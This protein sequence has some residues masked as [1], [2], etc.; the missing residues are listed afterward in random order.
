MCDKNSKIRV[1]KES[2]HILNDEKIRKASAIMCKLLAIL[3]IILNRCK[4]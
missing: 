2:Q 4:E 3:H 1:Q